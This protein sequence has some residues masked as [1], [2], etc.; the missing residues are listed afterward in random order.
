MDYHKQLSSIILGKNSLT[1]LVFFT[2]TF[3]IFDGSEKKWLNLFVN[4][5]IIV[6]SVLI[7]NTKSDSTLINRAIRN[8]QPSNI[9]Y[10]PPNLQ[11]LCITLRKCIEMV[12]KMEMALDA[13]DTSI[14]SSNGEMKFRGNLKS[15][16]YSALYI[17]IFSRVV[18][19]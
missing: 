2:I 18:L 15:S 4:E 8:C 9:K 10:L 14:S 12:N 7:C 1:N 19:V 16:T 6:V 3:L 5:V 17:F 11:D 13:I